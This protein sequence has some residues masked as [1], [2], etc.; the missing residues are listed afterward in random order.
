MTEEL[1]TTN[2]P[3]VI[4]AEPSHDDDIKDFI[5]ATAM[6]IP[7]S[8]FPTDLGEPT[9][10]RWSKRGDLPFPSEVNK[11]GWPVFSVLSSSLMGYT[12]G[13][14]NVGTDTD[15][16]GWREPNWQYQVYGVWPYSDTQTF[17]ADA[18]A[19]MYSFERH[20]QEQYNL[21]GSCFRSKPTTGGVQVFQ[22]NQGFYVAGFMNLRV[23]EIL[24]TGDP[25]D[26]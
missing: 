8:E 12:V 14:Q 9:I 25:I 13:A 15:L 22:S 5:V 4:P 10:F 24:M 23:I 19:C 17:R 18:E 2:R 21:G 1:L 26:G 3:I 6:A 20:Y 11:Q 7:T 16:D